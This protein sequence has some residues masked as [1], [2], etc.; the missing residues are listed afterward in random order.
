MFHL[1][2]ALPVLGLVGIGVFVLAI[3]FFA[4]T[5]L[6][7]ICALLRIMNVCKWVIWAPA[8]LGLSGLIASLVLLADDISVTVILIY[9]AVLFLWLWLIW[10]IVREIA[11]LVAHQRKKE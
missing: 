5:V 2:M 11:K 9:W 6:Q 7:V 8:V 10:L 3:P 1:M 4:G